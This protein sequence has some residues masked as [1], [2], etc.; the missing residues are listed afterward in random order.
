MTRYRYNHEGV[1]FARHPGV[2]ASLDRPASVV[3]F[4][5]GRRIAQV[6]R[7]SITGAPR[8]VVVPLARPSV[9]RLDAGPLDADDGTRIPV[10]CRAHPEGHDLDGAELRRLLATAREGSHI[11]VQV[12]RVSRR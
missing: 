10:P 2:L 5:R 3:I 8:L 1:S 7:G 12:S 6:Q 4:C 9:R 11:S